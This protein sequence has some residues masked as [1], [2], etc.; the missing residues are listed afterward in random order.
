MPTTTRHAT[1][2]EAQGC[3]LLPLTKGWAT[4]ID[5]ADVEYAQRWNWSAHNGGYAARKSR[6]NEVGFEKRLCVLLHRVIAERAGLQIGGLDVDHINTDKLDN[7]RS[8]LRAATR[9]Q[10]KH[11]VRRLSTN[12]SGVKGVHW[13]NTNEVWV[14]KLMVGGKS[15]LVGHFDRLDEAAAAHT[16]AVVKYH[17]EFGRTG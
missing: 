16:A 3:Y 2:D 14:C 12:R 17:G 10:N 9:S 5:E 13:C 15:I 4:L 1:Y 11:N 6:F 8:N 7:R